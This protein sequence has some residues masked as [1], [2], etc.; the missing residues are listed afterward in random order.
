MRPRELPAE[1]ERDGCER[2][3]RFG[4]ASMRPRELPAEDNLISPPLFMLASLQ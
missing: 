1:D 4:R 3:D 2:V